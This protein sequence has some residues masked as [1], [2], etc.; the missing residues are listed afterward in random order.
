M[1]EVRC[2]FRESSHLTLKLLQVSLLNMVEAALMGPGVKMT[3]EANYQPLAGLR[4]SQMKGEEEGL[5][6]SIDLFVVGRE[7][8]GG[9]VMS[10]G[11]QKQI[12]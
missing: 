10:V 1:W 11:Q 9:L 6:T 12:D 4:L 8:A 3:E 5:G 2:D 7:G